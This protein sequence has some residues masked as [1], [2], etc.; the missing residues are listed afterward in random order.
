MRHVFL[1]AAI[2]SDISYIS[3]VN[4]SYF[5]KIPFILPLKFNT[6]ATTTVANTWSDCVFYK[7]VI[8]DIVIVKTM[9]KRA[10]NL[11]SQQF[12]GLHILSFLFLLFGH[13]P[14]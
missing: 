11:L 14:K 1:F 2:A 5:G 7:I 10:A 8:E 9:W 3:K 4:K 13:M 12:A 6:A